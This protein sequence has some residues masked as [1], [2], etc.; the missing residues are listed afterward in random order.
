MAGPSFTTAFYWIISITEFISEKIFKLSSNGSLRNP[1]DIQVVSSKKPRIKFTSLNSLSSETQKELDLR[2]ISHKK[3]NKKG[4]EYETIDN[5][6]TL[7]L[8]DKDERPIIFT[9]NDF[10]LSNMEHCDFTNSSVIVLALHKE[11]HHEFLEF[12]EQLIHF[13]QLKIKDLTKKIILHR[14]V[15]KYL[16]TYSYIPFYLPNWL[17]YTDLYP[18]LRYGTLSVDF[19]VVLRLINGYY[20]PFFEIQDLKE[21]EIEN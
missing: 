13:L 9:Q 7:I 19:V 1:D 18:Y 16:K 10:R 12:R 2:V 5:S 3:T 14:L 4:E 17:K 15:P 11:G 21:E 20:C 8:T 6:K